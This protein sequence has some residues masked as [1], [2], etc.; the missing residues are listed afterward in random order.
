MTPTTLEWIARLIGSDVPRAAS[1]TRLTGRSDDSVGRG[2]VAVVAPSQPSVPVPVLVAPDCRAALSR[3]VGGLYGD[4]LSKLEYVG[5]T[6][7]NGKT[8][9]TYL[10]AAVMR[11]GGRKTALMGTL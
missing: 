9:T 7:T 1:S 10:S 3:A 8:T 6:G 5:V 2:A 4:L 11:A